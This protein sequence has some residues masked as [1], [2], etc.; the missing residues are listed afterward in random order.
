MPR[1]PSPR[2]YT[3][4]MENPGVQ[5]QQPGHTACS[6]CQPP[7]P[8]PSPRAELRAPTPCHGR[9]PSQGKPSVQSATLTLALGTTSGSP[10]L[11]LKPLGSHESTANNMRKEFYRGILL[12]FSLRREPKPWLPT[13]PPNSLYFNCR[14]GLLRPF[15][16]RKKQ[17][18][19]S[20]SNAFLSFI[21]AQNPNFPATR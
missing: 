7:A 19:E 6:P 11:H 14:K 9:L 1:C 12:S 13:C 18:P 2:R 5:E 20:P 4:S 16:P 3:A 10:A 8:N 17:V 21:T 15:A